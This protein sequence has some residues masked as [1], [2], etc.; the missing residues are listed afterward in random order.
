MICWGRFSPVFVLGSDAGLDVL[1]VVMRTGQ[2]TGT[3]LILVDERGENQIVIAPG[4][5]TALSPADVDAA[6][7]KIRRAG[8][9]DVL[10]R[11]LS[12]GR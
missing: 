5:N 3:A 6:A 1:G 11:R 4:A 8:L 9:P 12:V 2:T 10:W 7:D